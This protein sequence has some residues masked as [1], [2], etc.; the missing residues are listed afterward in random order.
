MVD[1]IRRIG[2]TVELIRTTQPG[3][4]TYEDELQVTAIP[5]TDR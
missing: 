1:L 3:Y 2:I 5:F 4:V